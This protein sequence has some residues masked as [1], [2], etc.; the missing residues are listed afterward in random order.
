MNLIPPPPAHTCSLSH[1][2]QFRCCCV[3]PMLFQEFVLFPPRSRPSCLC[4]LLAELQNSLFIMLLSCLSHGSE[5]FSGQIISFFFI[6]QGNTQKHTLGLWP[7]LLIN[8]KCTGKCPVS[9]RETDQN[10]VCCSA[11]V[12]LVEAIHKA[13]RL[14]PNPLHE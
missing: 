2:W 5:F 6:T 10:R 13:T 3:T 7:Y 14:C 4:V 11:C 1:I 8:L 12:R 9:I